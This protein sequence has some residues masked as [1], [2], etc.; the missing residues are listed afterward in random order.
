MCS[1]LDN[2]TSYNN[3]IKDNE[4]SRVNSHAD[5]DFNEGFDD[6]VN[7]YDINKHNIETNAKV[8][9][10]LN[11]KLKK[12]LECHYK[13]YIQTISDDEELNLKFTRKELNSSALNFINLK[14]KELLK[15]KKYK[16]ITKIQKKYNVKPQ[17]DLKFNYC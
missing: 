3:H 16:L 2:N 5:I 12:E 17:T 9:F 10:M 11:M 1:K 6:Y 7:N 13:S 8:Y 4:N 15:T 14:Y